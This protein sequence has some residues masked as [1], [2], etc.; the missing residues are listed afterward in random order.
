[1]LLY[2]CTY[3]AAER[4]AFRIRRRRVHYRF[5]Q[6]CSLQF[7]E[8]TVRLDVHIRD[9]TR[10][11]GWRK[12]RVSEEHPRFPLHPTSRLSGAALCRRLA[13]QRHFEDCHSCNPGGIERSSI[14]VE[15]MNQA[16]RQTH[17]QL[18]HIMELLVHTPILNV[19]IWKLIEGTKTM[20]G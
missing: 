1:V 16:S 11:D 5:Q 8:R 9:W 10:K 14:R 3:A 18:L 20:S 2:P 19:F 15:A 7:D 12:S 6:A 13:D 17:R 4:V